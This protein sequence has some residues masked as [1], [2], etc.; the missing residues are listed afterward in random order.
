M[1]KYALSPGTSYEVQV[2]ATTVL[3]STGVATASV[4]V[5][6]GPVVVRVKGGLLRSSAIDQPLVLDASTS[7]DLN[8]DSPRRSAGEK[9][10]AAEEEKLLRFSWECRVIS[11]IGYGES[12][13]QIF[14]KD[15]SLTSSRV[16]VV[17]MTVDYLYQVNVVVTASDGRSSS[18]SIT[19]TPTYSGSAKVKIRSTLTKF[20]TDST[21]KLVGDIRAGSAQTSYWSVLDPDVNLATDPLTPVWKNFSAYEAKIGVLF[22]LA[23]APDTFY[24]GKMYTFRLTSFSRNDSSVVGFGEILLGTN[25]PPSS[26]KL[27]VS[28][29]NGTAVFTVLSI[30]AS[31]WID[32]PSDYP[33]SYVFM[34]SLSEDEGDLTLAAKSQITFT[35][36]PLPAGLSSMNG[37]VFICSV[38]NLSIVFLLFLITPV[39]ITLLLCLKS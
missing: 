35:T 24:P 20:N 33:L 19:V 1:K 36:S 32:D 21:L 22:P 28:P 18:A 4:Y 23:V 17:N 37:T 34:Y 39:T 38:I 13:Y 31:S 15:S 10:L 12:C 14:K 30:S 29:P 3:G 26:G 27:V 5:E 16:T 11:V 9:A 7:E 25:A 8:V 2:T 6:Y